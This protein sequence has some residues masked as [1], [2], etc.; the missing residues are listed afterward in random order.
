MDITSYLAVYDYGIEV[1]RL[2]RFSRRSRSQRSAERRHG[3]VRRERRRRVEG[4]EP[5]RAHIGV[6][7]QRFAS[8]LRS[9][10]RPGLCSSNI[11]RG[12]LFVRASRASSGRGGNVSNSN[13]RLRERATA[14]QR[15]TRWRLRA[16]AKR[17]GIFRRPSRFKRQRDGTGIHSF[18]FLLRRWAASVQGQLLFTGCCRSTLSGGRCVGGARLSRQRFARSARSARW[19]GFCVASCYVPN[20]PPTDA[21]S[22]SIIES[23]KPLHPCDNWF[24]LPREIC[25]W[26]REGG[27]RCLR[28]EDTSLRGHYPAL[29]LMDVNDV[30]VSL[31]RF[32]SPLL[33]FFNSSLRNVTFVNVTIDSLLLSNVTVINFIIINS[34]IGAVSYNDC[35]FHNYTAVNQ[36]RSRHESN[37]TETMFPS[38][39]WRFFHIADIHMSVVYNESVDGSPTYCQWKSDA[40][41]APFK[42][43]YG[44]PCC[45]S[46][47]LLVD[48]Y[49]DSISAT[50][51]EP[52]V[53]ADFILVTGDFAGQRLY[54]EAMKKVALKLKAKF[55]NKYV[56]P[57]LEN[58]DL[59]DHKVLKTWHAKVLDTW[60]PLIRCQNCSWRSHTTPV[61]AKRLRNTFLKGGYYKVSLSNKMTML[62]LNTNYFTAKAVAATSR[63]LRDGKKQLKWLKNELA[64][65]ERFEKKVVIVGRT[66][67]GVDRFGRSLWTA[68]ATKAYVN[69]TAYRYPHIIAG[70]LFAHMHSETY[71]VLFA[72]MKNPTLEKSSPLLFSS[73]ITPVYDNNPNYRLVFLDNDKQRFTDF[74]QWYPDLAIE[75]QYNQT[76]RHKQY[77]FSELFPSRLGQVISSKRFLEIADGIVEPNESQTW[78]KYIGNGPS[79][80]MPGCSDVS[81]R[82]L[83]HCAMKYWDAS[84]VAACKNRLSLIH[85]RVRK[86]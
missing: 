21:V 35:H 65:A 59:S 29:R 44:K 51:A 6:A 5:E 24:C 46:P 36:N 31:S 22:T 53:N 55:P 30:S 48:S 14:R 34:T 1:L 16:T 38:A 45:E 20:A 3:I 37:L 73:A 41:I 60:T 26:N 72:D 52:N 80:Y 62:V 39:W 15:R 25:K 76:K 71:R 49:F 17:R 19:D 11:F 63:F 42:A 27:T 64:R 33:E 61:T 70:Q 50:D 23:Q 77:V 32:S 12:R 74:I 58:S 7:S 4:D 40:S 79:P 28:L 10:R 56:F 47:H 54:V 57:A 8:R 83:M 75:N 66:P 9:R 86:Q 67:P 82:F 18:K 78:L 13:R 2:D 81:S 84:A 43:L 85:F 68:D 69:I